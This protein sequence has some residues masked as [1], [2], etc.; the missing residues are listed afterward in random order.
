MGGVWAAILLKTGVAVVEGDGGFVQITASYLAGAE[1]ANEY[2]AGAE[3]REQY[4]AG[5][6]QI[7]PYLAGAERQQPQGGGSDIVDG[8]P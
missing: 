3:S 5:A 4:L 1:I 2:L 8:V 7:E 6:A